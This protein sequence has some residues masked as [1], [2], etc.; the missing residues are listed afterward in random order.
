MTEDNN[1]V[2]S[3]KAKQPTPEEA[4]KKSN[5]LPFPVQPR[6]RFPDLKDEA[7]AKQ[8]AAKIHFMH[9]EEAISVLTP[10]VMDRVLNAGFMINTPDYLKNIALIIESM[11]AIMYKY[12][13]FGHPLHQ[14]AENAFVM[15]DGQVGWSNGQTTEGTDDPVIVAEDDIMLEEEE[16]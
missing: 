10:Y 11:R 14:V 1:I 8:R 16:S 12:H 4:E 15:K 6:S 2:P 7:E 13:G 3:P 5:V 9:C